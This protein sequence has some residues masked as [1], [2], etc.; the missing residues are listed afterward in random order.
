MFVNPSKEETFGLT[1]LEAISCGTPAIVYKNTACEEVVNLFGGIA[2]EQ[3]VCAI[4]LA[5][6]QL[7]LGG[8]NFENFI[9][10]NDL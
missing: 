9:F 4:K 7:M 5:I 6:E 8:G 1:T 10:R 3:S 2:V